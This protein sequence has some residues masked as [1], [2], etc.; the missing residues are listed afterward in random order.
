[1]KLA[2]AEL[3]SDRKVRSVL[4]VTNSA[5]VRSKF[6]KRC[7]FRRRRFVL[8]NY[9]FLWTFSLEGGDYTTALCSAVPFQWKPSPPSLLCC[10][11]VFFCHGYP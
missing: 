1:M 5:D 2:G 6:D 8:M 4:S 3:F 7:Q 10:D 11:R 9:A